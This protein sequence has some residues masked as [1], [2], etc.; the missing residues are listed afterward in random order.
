MNRTFD[1]ME[2]QAYIEGELDLQEMARNDALIAQDEQAREYVI[3]TVRSVAMLKAE[4]NR[5]L[6][7][8][9]PLRLLEA[10]RTTHQEKGA[11]GGWFQLSRIAAMFLLAAIGFG[12]GLLVERNE[13]EHERAPLLMGYV[14]SQFNNVVMDALEHSVR[15]T[16]REWVSADQ[17]KAVKVT[18]VGTYRD[19]KGG[20]YRQYVMEM[21]MERERQILTG[22]AYRAPDG[23]WKTRSLQFEVADSI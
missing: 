12:G 4:M 9:I 1:E 18:P 16:S 10:V 19:S 7:E 6:D 20:Y 13:V 17:S 23:Q 22:L 2:L 3:K 5:V 15:G 14:P 8:P 11:R 21:T